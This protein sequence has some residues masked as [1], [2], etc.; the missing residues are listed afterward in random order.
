MQNITQIFTE[1]PIFLLV[2]SE[3][4]PKFILFSWVSKQ[5]LIIMSKIKEEDVQLT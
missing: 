4:I 1:I 2:K 5:K 3:D